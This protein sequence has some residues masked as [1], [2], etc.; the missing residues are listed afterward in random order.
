[1]GYLFLL[2]WLARSTARLCFTFTSLFLSISVRPIIST[3]TGPI[4]AKSAGFVG[5]TMVV[6]ERYEV[7]FPTTQGTLPRQQILVGFMQRVTVTLFRSVSMPAGFRRHLVGK[8][9]KN[10]VYYNSALIRFTGQ[11]VVAW[12]FS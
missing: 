3:S 5:R 6:D 2:I 1:M 4:F 11:L 9:L 10:A 7:S 8:T 12:S